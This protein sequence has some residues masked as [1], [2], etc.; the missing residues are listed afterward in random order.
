MASAAAHHLRQRKALVSGWIKLE[1]TLEDDPRV[2]KMA[3]NLVTQERYKCNAC[4]SHAVTLVLGSLARLWFYADTHVLDD[5]TLAVGI[6]D[7]GEIVGI[8]SFGHLL[9]G[10]WLEVI[11]SDH[12]KLPNFHTH[13]GTEAKRRA[14][15]QKRVEKHR[16]TVT[17]KRY[18]E[19]PTGNARVTQARLPDQDQD[20]DPD[21]DHKEEGVFS[22]KDVTGLDLNAWHDWVAYRAK[23]KP[24]IKPESRRKAAEQLAALGDG[25]RAAVDHSIANGYQGLIPPKENGN[26]QRTGRRL[27]RYEELTA[28][29]DRQ[30]AAGDE[31]MASNDRP[32]RG[33]VAT[34]LRP[35]AIG[36][37]GKPD[38]GPR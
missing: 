19:N 13:N 38:R 8:E 21:Q 25:Q 33:A 29:L 36:H 23:R 20:Q 31:A 22:E 28:D 6:D 35:A 4:A 17:H 14:T 32:I 2:K 9:P 7:I 27:T 18:K 15:T 30:I 1:K 24:A 11:D 26:G 10:D 37:M 5:D 34:E 12:V 3:K 16:K